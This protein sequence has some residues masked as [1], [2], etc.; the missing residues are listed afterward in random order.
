LTGGFTASVAHRPSFAHTEVKLGDDKQRVL[1][2]AGAMLWMDGNMRMETGCHNGCCT[3]Y[4]RTCAGESFCLNTFSGP[5]DVAF[6]FDLPGDILPFATSD[7]DGWIVTRSSFVC[8]TTNLRISAQFIGCLACCCSGEGTFLT[9][10]RSEEGTGNAL[11][12]AGNYGQIQRHEV[13]DGKTFVVNTGLFFAASDK[14][15][16]EIGLPGG[17][18]SCLF[19]GEG[20]VMKFRG[21]CTI[22]TQN[23]NPEDMKKLLNPYRG[24]EGGDGGDGGGGAVAAAM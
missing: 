15:Q 21:P 23:R 19:S 24:P 16:I 18:K 8:G 5:G 14:T 4:C 10:I 2:S 22:F 11:F 3:A 9:H 7:K 6:G 20:V 12:F 1:A 17:C 13:P